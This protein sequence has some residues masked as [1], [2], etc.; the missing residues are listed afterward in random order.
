MV[1]HTCCDC[2]TVPAFLTTPASRAMYE[3]VSG[4]PQASRRAKFVSI[5]GAA[6]S[7]TDDMP[8]LQDAPGKGDLT[9]ALRCQCAS[10]PMQQ[11]EAQ[12]SLIPASMATCNALSL[13]AFN[14]PVTC[15]VRW[16]WLRNGGAWS[17]L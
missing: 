10:S 4:H 6:H 14:L 17:E 16:P 13:Q 1:C 8:A 15:Y 3:Y 11:Q 2:T 7:M 9:P 12:A 5:A